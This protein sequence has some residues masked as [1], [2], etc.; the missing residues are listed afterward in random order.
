MAHLW[1]LVGRYGGQRRWAEWEQAPPVAPGLHCVFPANKCANLPNILHIPYC[2]QYS[3]YNLV[4]I[5]FPQKQK[6]T[7]LV[8]FAA[9]KYIFFFFNA[10]SEMILSF[11]THNSVLRWNVISRKLIKFYDAWRIFAFLAHANQHSF[12]PHKIIYVE[13]CWI[14]MNIIYFLVRIYTAK[15]QYIRSLNIISTNAIFS[16]RNLLMHCN[17]RIF[18]S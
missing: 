10:L 6:Q 18:F 11:V 4:A 9:I 5:P 13:V 3:E 16:T 1:E 14:Q 2:V 15:L 8:H 7:G 12:L 17:K